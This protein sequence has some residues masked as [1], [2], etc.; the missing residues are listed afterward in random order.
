MGAGVEVVLNASPCLK[1]KGT[2]FPVVASSGLFALRVFVRGEVACHAVSLSRWHD[3]LGHNNCRDLQLLEDKAIGMDI[4][5]RA[6]S[7]CEPCET[8]K[9]KRK[10]IKKSWGTR[11]ESVLHIVHSDILGPLH[12]ESV[13]GFRYAVGFVDSWSRY[14]TVYFMRSRDQ[15]FSKFQLFVADVGKPRLLVSDGAKEYL[16]REFEE[17]CEQQSIRREVS[18]PYT[19]EDNGKVERLWGDS[20]WNVS[21]YD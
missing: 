2:M 7:V 6:E 16:S 13:D 4:S 3:R 12:V 5:T 14:G 15:C 18:S 19:P 21:L 8:Q 10:P 1:V 17:F 9:A 11:A 20:C